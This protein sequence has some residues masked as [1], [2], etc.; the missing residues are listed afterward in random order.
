MEINILAGT[1]DNYS[2]ILHEE[3][4]ILVQCDPENKIIP[5]LNKL[6]SALDFITLWF[7]LGKDDSFL[8]TKIKCVEETCE[9]LNE[10]KE[11]LHSNT[12]F[13]Y[14]Q[15]S[16]RIITLIA[17]YKSI[18][19]PTKEELAKKEA[20]EEEELAKFQKEATEFMNKYRK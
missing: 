3:E 5:L 18:K 12:N 13:S 16:S 7:V 9:L 10:Y 19:N 1:L 14:D 17:K 8:E 6:S 2:S 15:I 20:K 11:I 4:K